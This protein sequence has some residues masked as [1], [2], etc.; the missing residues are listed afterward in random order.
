MRDISL[1]HN[2][3]ISSGGKLNE[4]EARGIQR[5]AADHSSPSYAEVVNGGA[6]TPLAILFHSTVLH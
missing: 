5:L 4:Y 1:L 6:V 2:E 3:E